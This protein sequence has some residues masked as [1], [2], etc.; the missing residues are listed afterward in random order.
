MR[1]S[2]PRRHD[3]PLNHSRQDD[4]GHTDQS[5]D[6]DGYDGIV[7]FLCHVRKVRRHREGLADIVHWNGRRSSTNEPPVHVSIPST[8]MSK[9]SS[10]IFSPANASGSFFAKSITYA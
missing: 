2:G 3:S 7:D 1:S 4:V 10:M 8:P 5:V 9:L 6:V